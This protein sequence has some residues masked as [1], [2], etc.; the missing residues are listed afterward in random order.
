MR[1]ISGKHKARRIEIPRNVT[2]RPTTDFAKESL[3]NLL[4]NQIDLEDI[5]V[6]DLFAGVGS[7]SLEFIS[8]GARSVIAVD[9]A[10]RQTSF[11]KRN[12][13]NLQADN[14]SVVKGDAIHYIQATK[15]K[16]DLV[17]ADPPYDF[18]QL[19]KIPDLV[20]ANDLLKEEGLFVLEH[21]KT[22]SFEEH[23]RFVSHRKYGNVHFSFFQ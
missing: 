23:E 2:A 8:R 16:F 20:F 22:H 11:I 14:L 13:Q 1:I 5:D 17:Y 18:E 4:N 3:F 7:I 21:S 6:L 15:I 19:A 12:A 10:H 9:V